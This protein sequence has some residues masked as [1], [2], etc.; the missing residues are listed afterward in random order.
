MISMH[1]SITTKLL[2]QWGKVVGSDENYKDNANVDRGNLKKAIYF[3]NFIN[4]SS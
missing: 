4:H 2:H 3:C 1:G